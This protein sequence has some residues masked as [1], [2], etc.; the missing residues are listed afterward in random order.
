MKFDFLADHEEA[1]PT[2]ARWYFDQ[3]GYLSAEATL[4]STIEKLEDYLRRDRIPFML[5]GLVGTEI[6][7]VAQLKFYEMGEMYPDREHWIGGVFVPPQF[8]GKGY[9]SRI[10]GEIAGR[11]PAYGVEVLHL[12]TERLDGGLYERLGW[13]PVE[14]ASNRGLEVLVMERR[15]DG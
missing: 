12:Q 4:E 7:A 8:R 10:A 5:V 2:I 13:R 9:A 15:L 3:W 14:R 6:C 1:L 11:A